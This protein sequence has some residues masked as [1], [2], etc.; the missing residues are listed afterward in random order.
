MEVKDFA[1][2]GGGMEQ[3]LQQQH[4]LG[5]FTGTY[6]CDKGSTG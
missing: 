4:Q 2:A 3:Q 6:N 5:S 1:D